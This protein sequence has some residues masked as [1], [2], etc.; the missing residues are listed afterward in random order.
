[1]EA[2]PVS[3][4]APS[5]VASSSSEASSTVGAGSWLAARADGTANGK[6]DRNAPSPGIG[7]PSGR[8]AGDCPCF[9]G[10]EVCDPS[11]AVEEAA[12]AA[13]PGIESSVA[14]NAK[15]SV[16]GCGGTRGAGAAITPEPGAAAGAV[17]ARP[18]RA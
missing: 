15:R 8:P 17:I 12:F 2:P 18:A 4:L 9:G 14:A 13:P 1:L 10:L 5:V 3:R 6:D 16:A 7:W 11:S